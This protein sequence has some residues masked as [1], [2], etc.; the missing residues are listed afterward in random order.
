MFLDE[1]LVELSPNTDT[2]AEAASPEPVDNVPRGPWPWVG[3]LSIALG[4]VAAVVQILAIVGATG[5]D[6]ERGI[7]LG[8]L[9]VILAIA[10][11]FAG[12]AAI[13]VRRGR[14]A[15]V[16]GILLGIVANPLVLLAILRFVDGAR[17]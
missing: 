16:V 12:I 1:Q 4:V 10:A 3:A 17:G 8:Y 9:S 14:R 11:V 7:V 13:I 15:G 6:F 5:G 2:E